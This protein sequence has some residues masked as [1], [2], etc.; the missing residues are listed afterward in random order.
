[1]IPVQRCKPDAAEAC[2]RWLAFWERELT[3]RPCCLMRAPRTGAEPVEPPRY[4]AGARGPLQPVIERILAHT[5]ATWWGGDA[6]PYY[7]PSFGPD[8]LA[9]WLGAELEFGD[10]EFGTNWAVPCVEDWAAA[11]PLCLDPANPWWRRMLDFCAALATAGTD[12]LIVAH[13][14]L[15]SNLDALAAM[16]GPERLC[17]DLMDCPEAVT[18][19]LQEARRLYRPIYDAVYAAGSM[20]LAGTCGWV[21]AYHPTRTNTI[22]CD[23]AAL[24]GPRNFRR[25]VLP[26]LEEEAAFL[27]HCVFHLDGPECLVHLDRIC[28]IPGVDCIQWVPGAGNAPFADWLPLLRDIQARGVSVWVPCDPDSLRFYHRELAPNLVCYNCTAPTQSEGEAALGWLTQN[29]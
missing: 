11:P 17:L 20:A 4:M 16:R 5:A 23:F 6:I 19:A 2:T 14:D 15:H 9:A 12:R 27:G 24:L 18:G 25:F 21:P 8:M 1:M 3:D 26:A 13:L 29:T 28:A 10:P 22:Q 7:S